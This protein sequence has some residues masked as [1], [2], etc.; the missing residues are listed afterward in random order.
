MVQQRR[1]NASK[2]APRLS[3]RAPTPTTY[4]TR[5]HTTDP[6]F[7]RTPPD[8]LDYAKGKSC[9]LV[10]EEHRHVFSAFREIN[11]EQAQLILPCFPYINKCSERFPQVNITRRNRDDRLVLLLPRHF[12]TTLGAVKKPSS[13]RC[14]APNTFSWMSPSDTTSCRA[15]FV[16]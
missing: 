4:P 15:I 2:T 5:P 14:A 10:C 3:A 1:Q 8:L 9:E 6:G 12:S 16:Q 11:M 13:D 7:L